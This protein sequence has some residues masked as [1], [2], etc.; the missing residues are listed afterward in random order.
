VD[1]GSAYVFALADS[2]GDG[3]IDAQDNC[4]LV[5]N[6]DQ[7]DSDGDGIGDAC[8]SCPLDAANDADADGI[9]GDVDNCPN[10]ANPDQADSDGDG[11]GDACSACSAYLDKKSCQSDASCTWDGKPHGGFCGKA[12]TPVDCS[13]YDYDRAACK[14]QRSCHWSPKD[15][16]CLTK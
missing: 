8:D 16:L 3:I 2:D 6:P 13:S 11:I 14:D 12:P 1:S 10:V 15:S 7:A 5:A 4:T 9:C